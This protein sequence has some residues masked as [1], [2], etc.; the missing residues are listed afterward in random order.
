VAAALVLTEQAQA[1]GGQEQGGVGSPRVNMPIWRG[2]ST[3][4][5][6]ELM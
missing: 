1:V 3:S 6:A 4:S 2:M 5:H